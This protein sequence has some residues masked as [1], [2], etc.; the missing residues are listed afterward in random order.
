MFISSE[1]SVAIKYLL[2]YNEKTPQDPLRPQ[3]VVLLDYVE[4]EV[5]INKPFVTNVN[6][7]VP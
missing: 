1:L 2:W 5:F 7:M 6:W 3:G 4:D